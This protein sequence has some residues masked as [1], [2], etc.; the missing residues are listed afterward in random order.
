[1]A[2]FPLDASVVNSA[3]EPLLFVAAG[4][5]ED[6]RTSA[7]HVHARGQLIGSSRGVLTVGVVDAVWI[8]PATH[9]VWLPPNHLHWA[10]AHGRFDGW[11]LYVAEDAC[12]DLPKAPRAIRTSGL[13]REAIARAIQWPLAPLD[14]VQSRLAAVIL[15]E[16]RQLP[17]EALGLPMP[18]DSRL[19]RVAQA[20]VDDPTDGRDLEAWARWT[21][22]SARTLSRRFV[23]ETGFSFTTWR[24]RARLLRGLEMLASGD[25]VTT[26]AL[27]LGFSSASAFIALFRRTFGETPASY[28]KRL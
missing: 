1:M 24:Q 26:I 10:G 28:K 13:L 22:A 7:P 6:E 17:P 23:A 16:I 25:S 11:A 5:Q 15:D 21:G 20:L 9:A 2:T 4:Q 3:S 27:D 14:A 8:V 12:A 18:K 19:A